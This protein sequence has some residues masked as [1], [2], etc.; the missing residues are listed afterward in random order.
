MTLMFSTGGTRRKASGSSGVLAEDQL[1]K[2][3]KG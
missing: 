2:N 3:M 1:V